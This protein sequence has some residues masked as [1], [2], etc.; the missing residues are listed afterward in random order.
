MRKLE[1]VGLWELIGDWRQRGSH[2]EAKICMLTKADQLKPIGK[3]R[4]VL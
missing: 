1:G 3:K 2:E 4:Q